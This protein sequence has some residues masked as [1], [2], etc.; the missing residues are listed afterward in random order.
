MPFWNLLY[1]HIGRMW[2][3][4]EALNLC[5]DVM[6]RRFLHLVGVMVPVIGP[7]L[8]SFQKAVIP[9]KKAVCLAL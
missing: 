5:A 7:F 9:V 4:I 1:S 2:L 6:S 8:S 3:L